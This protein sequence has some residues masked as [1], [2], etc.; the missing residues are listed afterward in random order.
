MN[1]ARARRLFV[2]YGFASTHDAL[3][4]ERALKDAGVPVVPVPA[5]GSL[6]S[7]C[8]IAMRVE[9]SDATRAEAA[10]SAAGQCWSGCSEMRDV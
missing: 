6:G 10:M 4:A 7:L 5:P 3:A 8:G 2:V 9:P 1:A